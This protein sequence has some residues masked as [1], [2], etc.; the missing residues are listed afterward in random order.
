MPAEPRIDAHQQ[1][2]DLAVRP[3]PRAAD[4]PE[5]QRSFRF[6]DAQAEL[7]AHHFDATILVQ[8]LADPDETRDLL[9]LAAREAPGPDPD[10]AARDLAVRDPDLAVRDPDVAAREPVV[11]GVIG[12]ADL[13]AA[14]LATQ[15]SAL[16]AQPGGAALVGVRYQVDVEP[17]PRWLRTRDVRRG[18]AAVAEAGLVF[19]L[20]LRPAQLA[21]AVEAAAELPELRFVL[22][23]AGGPDIASGGLE[24]WAS[25]I[26]DLALLPNVAVKLSGLV[27]AAD[28]DAWTVEQLRPY[29]DVLTE[30]FEPDRIMFGSD[31]PVCLLAASY[32]V[33]VATA[34]ALVADLTQSERDAIFG[35]TAASW[36]R[37]S[38]L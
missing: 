27:T 25:D 7:A 10:R 26:A 4:A 11:A 23:H 21:A 30:A 29:V 1:I 17:D 28:H 8:T 19:D 15:L 2:W 33:W 16:L 18:L 36:Y 34:T 5:L 37:P 32:D 38:H 20:L 31:W 6:A 13:A 12:W 22:D 24:P 14:D 35:G 9:A 3:E